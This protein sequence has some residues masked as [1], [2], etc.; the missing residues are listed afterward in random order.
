[1]SPT[2]TRHRSH[3]ISAYTTRF[4]TSLLLGILGG[5]ALHLLVEHP[6]HTPWVD[7]LIFGGVFLCADALTTTAL[8]AWQRLRGR[9][10]LPTTVRA[11]QNSLLAEYHRRSTR[12]ES[13]AITS[14]DILQNVAGEL[15]GLRTAIGVAHGYRADTPEAHYA[16]RR[17]HA[18]WVSRKRHTASGATRVTP[19]L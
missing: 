19:T 1:M 5:V 14:P 15:V 11:I 8:T 12:C 17:L 2:D 9:A 3:A 13:G 6:R 7:G 18:S 16:A 10:Q 4:T